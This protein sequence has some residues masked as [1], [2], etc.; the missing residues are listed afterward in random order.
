MGGA[1]S[2]VEEI[3][4]QRL[5]SKVKPRNKQELVDGTKTFWERKVTP[6]K[7]AKYIDH[8]LHK[9]V[10]AMVEAREYSYIAAHDTSVFTRMY[11]VDGIRASLQESEHQPYD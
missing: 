10:P 3:G 7:C 8:V 5:E 1:L 9:V 2:Q 6:E 11:L 4:I